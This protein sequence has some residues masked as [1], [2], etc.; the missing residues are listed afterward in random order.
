MMQINRK[1]RT[2]NASRRRGATV[3]LFAVMLVVVLTFF[4]LSV[5]LGY[6]CSVKADLQA[7]ADSG[8]LAGTGMLLEGERVAE[9][10]ATR[11]TQTNMNNQ[12]VMVGTKNEI[13][14][15][16]G[17]WSTT[18]RTFIPGGQPR[19]AVKVIA[20]ANDA[21]LFFGRAFGNR[22]VVSQA[23]AVAAYRPR[24]I[25]LVLDVSGSMAESR[26]GM[27]KIDE[28]RDAVRF[29]LNYIA[30]GNGRDRVGFTYYSSTARFG[31]GLSY[32][33][34]LVEKKLMKVL[35]PGSGTNIA[36]G[37]LLA[38]EEMDRNR[39]TQAA[40]LIV[41]LTDGAANMIQPENVFDIPEAKSRVI[42]QAEL[43]KRD[44]L[45][46]F[47]MALDSLT[48]EVDVRLMQQ[49]AEITGSESY[50]II[51]G[52]RDNNGN[53]QLREAF[54]RVAMNRPLRLVE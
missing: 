40:P 31:M 42:E 35:T 8:A 47:T 32:D 24:D 21:S 14:V 34:S 2:K 39:R 46:I 23:K 45:P 52:E 17:H 49:V 22:T 11:F 33:L 27:R 28:L 13:D 44:G 6:V 18:S 7:A 41:L 54:R 19:D 38:R 20:T 36:D 1:H 5:D 29:F 3:V 53:R 48:A 51:A 43:A 10:A 4:A 9:E 30:K 50:H 26:G 12:G 15:Q 25:M 16:T 37:M